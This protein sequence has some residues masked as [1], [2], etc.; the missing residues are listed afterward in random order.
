MKFPMRNNYQSG[1]EH[2]VALNTYF[3]C[4]DQMEK[5]LLYKLAATPKTCD[6]PKWPEMF[7]VDVTGTMDEAIIA[8]AVHNIVGTVQQHEKEIFEVAHGMT[9]EGLSFIAVRVG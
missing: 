8:P 6:C 9:K 4:C 5:E 1:E 2:L 3:K 7:A